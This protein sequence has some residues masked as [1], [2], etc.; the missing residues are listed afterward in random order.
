M[1]VPLKFT[2]SVFFMISSNRNG[3]KQPGKLIF[4]R[5]LLVGWPWLAARRP[6]SCP[7]SLPFLHRTRG[8]NKMEKLMGWDRHHLIKTRK[9][10]AQKQSKR[11]NAFT[12]SH[13]Q[14]DV[15]PYLRKQGPS[16]CSKRQT[17]YPQMSL[18]PPLSPQ[19]LLLSTMPYGTG[20]PFGLLVSCPGC[21]PS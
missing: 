21:V 12:T 6:P 7:L 19:L 4:V 17:P 15:Q 11:R 10:C 5:N 9:S 1:R 14:T 2:S 3:E 20:H 13:Q 8:E 18:H 16:V